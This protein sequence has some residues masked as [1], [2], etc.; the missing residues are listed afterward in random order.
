MNGDT[1][2]DRS[3][4]EIRSAL[5]DIIESFVNQVMEFQKQGVPLEGVCE[6]ILRRTPAKSVRDVI[7]EYIREYIDHHDYLTS[8]VIADELED[9]IPTKSTDPRKVIL[10]TIS[11]MTRENILE[12]DSFGRISLVLKEETITK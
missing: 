3:V 6:V 12:R 4:E 10:S 2:Q 9:R 11:V 8:S 5:Q 7:R 1:N